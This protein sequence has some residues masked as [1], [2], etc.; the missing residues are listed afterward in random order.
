MIVAFCLGRAFHSALCHKLQLFLSFFHLVTC[1]NSCVGLVL[2]ALLHNVFF[3]LQKGWR[4]G[5]V[6]GTRSSTRV[7]RVCFT[8]R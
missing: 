3:F 1:L 7:R 6:S 5:C 8:K 2:T 4:S